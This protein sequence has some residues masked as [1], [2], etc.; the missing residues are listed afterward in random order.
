MAE[1]LRRQ[2]RVFTL[3]Q[4]V[5]CRSAGVPKDSDSKSRSANPKRATICHYTGRGFGFIRRG[6]MGCVDQV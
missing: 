3:P 6:R 2:R 1:C 4:Y 5:R